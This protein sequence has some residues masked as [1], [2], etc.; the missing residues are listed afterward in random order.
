MLYSHADI[1]Y[2]TST[3]SACDLNQGI[4]SFPLP[5]Y[6]A[7]KVVIVYIHFVEVSYLPLARCRPE[8]VRDLFL[9]RFEKLAAQDYDR[10]EKAGDICAWRGKGTRKRFKKPRKRYILASNW[11]LR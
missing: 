11:I 10:F 2:V 6:S 7:L 4:I 3:V 5:G 8:I 9:L 1:P